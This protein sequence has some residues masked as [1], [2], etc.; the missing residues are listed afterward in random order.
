MGRMRGVIE[1][2]TASVK[3]HRCTADEEWTF[4]HERDL[5]FDEVRSVHS[6]C[7]SLCRHGSGGRY[8]AHA[9]PTGSG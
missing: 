1:E 9:G 7:M 4:Q 3:F 5:Q 2:P 8:H 6:A